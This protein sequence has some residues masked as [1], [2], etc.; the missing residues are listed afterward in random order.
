MRENPMNL[1]MA[2]FAISRVCKKCRE[3]DAAQGSEGHEHC[4]NLLAIVNWLL[5]GRVGLSELQRLSQWLRIRKGED[6]HWDAIRE[7]MQ[8]DIVR[9]K[10]KR[11]RID[12]ALAHRRIVPEIKWQEIGGDSTEYWETWQEA[13]R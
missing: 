5:D 11:R 2:N 12:R 6:A 1:R 9:R 4:D 13:N 8:R 3:P 10:E 7:K